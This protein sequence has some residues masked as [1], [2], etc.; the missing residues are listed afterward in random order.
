MKTYTIVSK[1]NNDFV[2]YE[3]GEVSFS[4]DH[5]KVYLEKREADKEME[6]ILLAS[7]QYIPMKVVPNYIKD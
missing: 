2:I 7:N 1:E 6:E 3:N 4:Q 5:C